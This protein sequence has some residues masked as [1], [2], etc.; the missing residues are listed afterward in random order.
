MLFQ[1][2]TTHFVRDFETY[3]LTQKTPAGTTI[4]INTSKNYIKCFKRIYNQALKLGVYTS[5]NADPFVLF[6]NKRMPVEQKRLA[7]GQVESM[8]Q[9]QFEKDHPLF[10]TRNQFL[11]QIFCQGLRVSDL[12]TLRF[13]NIDKSIGRIDFTQFKTKKPNS[14]YLNDN[15]LLIL[16]DYIKP[17]LTHILNE[18]YAIEFEDGKIEQL[19]FYDAGVKYKEIV[20]A[21]FTT[22]LKNQSKLGGK[23]ADILFIEEA[24]KV[25]EKF[26]KYF[27]KISYLLNKGLM[28]YA[29]RHP[30]DFIFPVLKNEDFINVEFNQETKLSKYQYNQ[31]QSKEAMYNKALKKLQAHFSID[32]NLTSHISRHTYASLLFERDPKKIYE[33]SKGLGHTNMRIT[34]GY[35]KAFDADIVDQPNIEFGNSF[36]HL[37]LKEIRTPAAPVIQGPELRVPVGNVPKEGL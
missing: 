23:K 28:E 19:D 12:F 36:I 33:I 13:K 22:S 9:H 29:A 15:L 26:D 32:V 24:A 5:F 3:I 25:K 30:K 31:L 10:H 8:Y 16:K 17:D 6:I 4:K 7:R 18:K 37:D 34:E 20:G 11:F 35:L 14:I 2:V 27:M 1:Q 21:I